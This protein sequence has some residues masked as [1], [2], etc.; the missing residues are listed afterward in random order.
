VLDLVEVE[1][2]SSLESLAR[3]VAGAR[4]RGAAVALDDVTSPYRT[5][6]LCEA[7]RPQWAKV[8]CD[9]TR[10]VAR[11]ARRRSILK[12]FGRLARHFS[13]DLIAEGVENAADLDVCQAAGVVAAQGYFVGHPKPEPEA[14][15]AAF[16]DWIS[17]HGGSPTEDSDEN[18][19]GSQTEERAS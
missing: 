11:D 16:L 10:G 12:F 5:I 6:Q 19:D 3:T 4:E 18:V 13:F 17:S 2:V 14:P 15:E 7:F 1:N 9:I 8:D